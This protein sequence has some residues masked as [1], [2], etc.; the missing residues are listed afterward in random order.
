MVYT[1]TSSSALTFQGGSDKLVP[2]IVF[3]VSSRDIR[4]F[5]PDPGFSAL[6]NMSKIMNLQ[7]F[8]ISS[9]QMVQTR[10]PRRCAMCFRSFLSSQFFPNAIWSLFAF[11]GTSL[12]QRRVEAGALPPHPRFCWPKGLRNVGLWASQGL[13]LRIAV[14]KY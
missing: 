8:A 13:R 5:D 10:G 9:D 2:Y 7:D 1:K 12:T 11:L 14:R 4:H 6:M 3:N